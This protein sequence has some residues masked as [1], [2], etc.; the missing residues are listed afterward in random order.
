MGKRKREEVLR[1]KRRSNLPTA[2]VLLTVV[3]VAAGLFYITTSGSK[4]VG[5]ELK[6]EQRTQNAQS[7]PQQSSSAPPTSGSNGKNPENQG[8]RPE[9]NRVKAA[10]D[11]VLKYYQQKYTDSSVTASAKD[12]GCHIEVII[13]KN[14]QPI[15]DFTYVNG[16]IYEQP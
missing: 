6:G 4:S 13:N 7:V 3:I 15:K 9:S 10:I 16:I 11:A 12:Y 8:T 2:I 14:G 5:A 1:S